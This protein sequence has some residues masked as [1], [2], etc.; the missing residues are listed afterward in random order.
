MRR[1]FADRGLVRA[2]LLAA[3][4]LPAAAPPALAAPPRAA[5]AEAR[6][7]Y[8][9]GRE[10]FARGDYLQALARFE[11]AYELDPSP[12]LR[13]NLARAAEEL[14]WADRAV[15]HYRA[16]LEAS[17]RAEDREEVERRVRVMEK[18][19]EV[20]VARGTPRASLRPW[21]MAAFGGALV[22]FAF[23]GGAALDAG[24]LDERRKESFVAAERETLKALEDEA[25][26]RAVWG[27]ALGLLLAGGGGVLW[28]LDG[29]GPGRG[30]Q[31]PALSPGAA[32]SGDGAALWFTGEF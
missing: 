24:D 13:F 23:A 2:L 9:E 21:A 4:A 19:V 25:D 15:V 26:T 20:T 11:R 7:A 8:R 6:S 1:S 5:L 31:A 22:S 12:V 27:V 3:L 32:P 28:W 17:P 18:V 10:A 16:Y 29:P 14:G 30:T